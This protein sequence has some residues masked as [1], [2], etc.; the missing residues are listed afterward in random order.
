MQHGV[1]YEVHHIYPKARLRNTEAEAERHCIA[2]L[3][4]ITKQE[5][6]DLS[7]ADP[8]IYLPKVGLSVRKSHCMPEL[9]SYEGKTVGVFWK[10]RKEQLAVAFNEFVSP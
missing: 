2:N 1:D 3:T 5:N 9:G 6:R 8:A 10:K 7:D 4:F